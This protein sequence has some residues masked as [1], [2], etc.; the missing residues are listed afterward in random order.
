MLGALT[1]DTC[2]LPTRESLAQ[3][4]SRYAEE[5]RRCKERLAELEQQMRS[6]EESMAAFRS[7]FDQLRVA[8]MLDKTVKV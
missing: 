2:A 3:S 8:L 7:Q 5:A 4:E 6:S 1:Q